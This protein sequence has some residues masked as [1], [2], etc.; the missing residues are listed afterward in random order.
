MPPKKLTKSTDFWHCGKIYSILHLAGRDHQTRH[1]I[2]YITL[3][4][5]PWFLLWLLLIKTRSEFIVFPSTISTLL[6]I[7]K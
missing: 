5:I 2:F 1:Q 4:L 3:N 7:N 6:Q